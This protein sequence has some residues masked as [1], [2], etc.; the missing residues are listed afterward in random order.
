ATVPDAVRDAKAYL[1]RALAAASQLKV[2][3]G[4]GPVH[5]FHDMWRP[6]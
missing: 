1:T 6:A 3:S 4:H 2:G 5:H